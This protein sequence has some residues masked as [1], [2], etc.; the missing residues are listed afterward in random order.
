MLGNGYICSYNTKLIGARG[1]GKQGASLLRHWTWS[2]CIHRAGAQIT[3][4]SPLRSSKLSSFSEGPL[5]CFSP[6]SH[7]R[8]VDTL[9]LI[10]DART[11]WLILY[12]SRRARID[13][14]EYS[15]TGTRHRESYSFI[16]RFVI[17]PA[18]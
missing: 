5:G 4:S 10:M 3:A 13:A 8:T 7:C 9:V 14:L 15:G 12:L 1:R 18:A 16:R 2:L 17:N 11:A 6:I